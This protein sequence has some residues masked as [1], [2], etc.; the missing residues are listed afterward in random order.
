LDDG[1]ETV[2]S[3][4]LN[5]LEHHDDAHAAADFDM[6]GVD[7]PEGGPDSMYDVG[8]GVD[9]H[10]WEDSDSVRSHGLEVDDASFGDSDDEMYAH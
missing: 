5:N 10:D 9:D 1:V 8:L 3:N 2:D 6:G 4:A 7:E